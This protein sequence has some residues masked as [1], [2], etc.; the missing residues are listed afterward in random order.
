MDFLF[1]HLSKRILFLINQLELDKFASA[2]K[3]ASMEKELSSL[4]SKRNNLLQEIEKTK[5]IIL[6]KTII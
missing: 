2:E 5:K 4:L 3:R 1:S 6:K